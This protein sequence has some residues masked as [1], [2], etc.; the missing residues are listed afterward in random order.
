MDIEGTRR[1][2]W[3]TI[4]ALVWSGAGVILFAFAPAER[5]AIW[6]RLSDVGFLLA[7]ALTAFALFA[8]ARRLPVEERLGWNTLTAAVGT[9]SIGDII[10]SVSGLQGIDPSYPGP[11]DVA[12]ALG[13]LLLFVAAL[14]LPARRGLPAARAKW[15]LDATIATLAVG[16]L[17]WHTYLG[18]MFAAATASGSLLTRFV[19]G[20]YP[21]FD[22]LKITA[23][24]LLMVRPTRY[25]LDRRVLAVGGAIASLVVAN[26]LYME[27]LARGTYWSGNHVSAFWFLFYG[28]MAVGAGLIDRPGPV[29]T[30][31]RTDRWWRT[32][33]VY[34]AVG[35]MLIHEIID[36]IEG[37]VDSALS[38]GSAAVVLLVVVRQTVANRESRQLLEQQRNDLVASVSHE[39]RTPLAAVH[40]FTELLIDDEIP[41]EDKNE[42][43]VMVHEQSSY[44]NRIV[45]D[46][47]AT[48]RGSL[49]QEELTLE[50]TSIDDLVRPALAASMLE[51]RTDLDIANGLTALCDPERSRQIVINTLSNAGRYGHGR[52][53]LVARKAGAAIT[54]EVHDDGPG[55]PRKY[56]D[57]IWEQFERGAHRLDAR[58]PGSG[59]GLSIARALAIAQGGSMSYRPSERL[60]GACF[61]LIIPASR[62]PANRLLHDPA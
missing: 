20:G 48:A 38:L 4:P 23:L 34:L 39:L 53:A 47:V 57:L 12:Y 3:F 22:L 56:Q 37:D 62:I 18:E 7:A 55:V 8:A 26:A 46:L 10:W 50:P 25:V 36:T 54:I 19:S 32:A 24:V 17:L 44:L 1:F 41:I 52:I 61:S 9:M 40:G 29:A 51:S 2:P 27:E 13:Y 42:V 33:P 31:E 58:I 60:G 6:S 15:L 21:I 30:F 35:A 43:L 28:L 14:R 16:L 45:S 11:A 59:L 49:H 5:N